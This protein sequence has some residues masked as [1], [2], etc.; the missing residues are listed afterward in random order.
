MA[1]GPCCSESA[2][3]LAVNGHSAPLRQHCLLGAFLVLRKGSL[4]PLYSA[5]TGK[6]RQGSWTWEGER[7]SSAHGKTTKKEG[8]VIFAAP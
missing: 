6:M 7:V 8:K 5:V 3:P 1:G 2:V 4:Y